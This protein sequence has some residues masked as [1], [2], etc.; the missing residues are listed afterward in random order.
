MLGTSV[1]RTAVPLIVGIIL[2]LPISKSLGL[3]DE[4]VTPAVAGVLTL[5]YYIVVRLLETRRGKGWGA[6]LGRA[7][8]P[9]YPDQD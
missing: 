4:D 2:A 7:S 6:L 5:I 8:P 1:I 9:V 3:T